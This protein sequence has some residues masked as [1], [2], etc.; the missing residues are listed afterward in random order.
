MA[1]ICGLVLTGLFTRLSDP[2]IGFNPRYASIQ[3]TYTDRTS[4]QLPDFVVDFSGDSSNFVYG[5]VPADLI[6]ETSPFSY[7]LVTIS[8]DRAVSF[9]PG[10]G[11]RVHYAQ[12]SGRIQ[13]R[14]QVHLSWSDSGVRDFETWPNAVIDAVYSTINAP[15][16]QSPNVSPNWGQGLVY[17]YDLDF[18]KSPL[19][20]A[21]ENWRRLVSFV[22]TFEVL[23]Y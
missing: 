14:V 1:D 6:E 5:D 11:Q 9:R 22:G 12:F 15:S 19:I 3:S 20:E 8:A 13:F 17:G 16:A 23:A 18:Q 10:S 7:P 2:A 21:G 4:G